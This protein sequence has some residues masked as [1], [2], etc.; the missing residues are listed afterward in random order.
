MSQIQLKD[1]TEEQQAAFVRGWVRAGGCPGDA[2][3]RPWNAAESVVLRTCSDNPEDWGAQ[4]WEE[5]K[6][7]DRVFLAEKEAD[8]ITYV[9]EAALGELEHELECRLYRFSQDE[10]EDGRFAEAYY[11]G[12]G[13][14]AYTRTENSASD[15][16]ERGDRDD[17]IG[18]L[19]E[20]ALK[21]AVFVVGAEREARERFDGR[22]KAYF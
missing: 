17:L 6:S 20:E 12:D 22:Y 21:R 16:A 7:E 4:H 14:S 5:F 15:A 3:C 2:R 11:S 10:L 19:V 9:K 8:R 1:L 13:V 18:F